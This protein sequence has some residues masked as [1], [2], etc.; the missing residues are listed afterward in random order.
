MYFFIA[1]QFIFYLKKKKTKFADNKSDCQSV[2]L[3]FF[4]QLLI[5]HKWIVLFPLIML[6]V[7]KLLSRKKYK[8]F[9]K[10]YNFFKNKV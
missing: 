3:R 8:L 6:V 10:I 7:G 5:I 1:F 2:H 4:F 9:E